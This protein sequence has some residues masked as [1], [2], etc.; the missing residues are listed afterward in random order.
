[1]G[2]LDQRV[3]AFL[4][5][6]NQLKREIRKTQLAVARK[7]EPGRL[8]ALLLPLILPLGRRQAAA[9]TPPSSAPPPPSFCAS[10]ARY[11]SSGAASS[12]PSSSPSE[13]PAASPTPPAAAA[14]EEGPATTSSPP[15]PLPSPTS[16]S[17]PIVLRLNDDP[18]V[19]GLIAPRG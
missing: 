18:D 8:A 5:K 15:P 16:I 11:R 3:F 13:P 1:M 7:W 6:N 10:A 14:A 2:T 19:R 4:H 9:P 12:S 17:T